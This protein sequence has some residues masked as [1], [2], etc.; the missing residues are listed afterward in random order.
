MK[1]GAPGSVRSFTER[2]WGRSRSSSR[3]WACQALRQAW[4]RMKPRTPGSIRS[5][6]SGAG[7]GAGVA[8]GAGP[9]GLSDRL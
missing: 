9:V 4:Y 7:G 5:V 1:P 3:S 8:A 6:P 2:R